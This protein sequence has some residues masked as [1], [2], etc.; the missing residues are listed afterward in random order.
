MLSLKTGLLAAVVLL[1]TGCSAGMYK[2]SFV[3]SG[4]Y[5]NVISDDADAASIVYREFR[6][7]DKIFN[8]YD[9][10]SE[11]SNLNNSF[12]EWVLVSR[13]LFEVLSFSK[14]LYHETNGAFD[15][16]CGSIFKLWKA[17][18]I[19]DKYPAQI[20]IDSAIMT[21]G[22]D[23]VE[24]NTV[25]QAVKIK[26]RGLNIDLSSIAK[27]YMVRCA[28]DMLGEYG[29][30]NA[31]IDAGGDIYCMGTNNGNEWRVGVK[32]AR[33][34]GIIKKIELSDM[35]VATSG[36]YEQFFEYKGRMYSHIIDVRKGYPVNNGSVGVSVIGDDPMVLDALAT[37]FF[38]LGYY[39]AKALKNEHY[40]DLKCEFITVDG[41]IEKLY[42]F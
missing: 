38:V 41:N 8:I 32:D 29:I 25:R 13:E 2:N 6:R 42:T 18:I 31:V 5:L 7:L 11:I 15:V 20:D 33:A 26:K 23:S 30:K 17:A 12:N 22:M 24:I 19:N 39:D 40:S 35:G 34:A 14:K 21:C 28:A 3:V 27:G 16:S 10:S 1:I 37:S 4:T 36:D 9:K